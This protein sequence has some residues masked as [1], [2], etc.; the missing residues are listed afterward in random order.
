MAMITVSEW[1]WNF[2]FFLFFFSIFIHFQTWISARVSDWAIA[3]LAPDD[4]YLF[5]SF[6]VSCVQHRVWPLVPD[7]K[8]KLAHIEMAHGE[9]GKISPRVCTPPKKGDFMHGLLG[10]RCEEE[11]RLAHVYILVSF[12][13]RWRGIL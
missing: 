11:K 12:P 8:R 2:F 1:D 9:T 3:P 13:L 4:F 7:R 10:S 5:I 6:S